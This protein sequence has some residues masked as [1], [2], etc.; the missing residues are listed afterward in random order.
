MKKLTL[1]AIIS[2]LLVQL[3][4]YSLEFPST[5][6]TGQPA[7]TASGG[8]RN[9]S[10]VN[11]QAMPPKAL[12][13]QNQLGTTVSQAPTL[14]FYIPKTNTKTAEFALMDNQGNEIFL[15]KIALP[16]TSGVIKLDLPPTVQLETNK[17]YQWELAIICDTQDQTRDRF[18]QGT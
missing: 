8:R 4:V 12:V 7:R 2:T 13:P 5:S 14:F 1:A 9:D 3:P 16:D 18:I 15:K 11:V 17:T 10:C 6:G